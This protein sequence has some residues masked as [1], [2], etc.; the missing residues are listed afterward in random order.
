M[1]IKVI[2]LAVALFFSVSQIFGQDDEI[3]KE[4]LKHESEARKFAAKDSAK[5]WTIGGVGSLTFSQVALSNWQ[6]G[7]QNSMAVGSLFNV[8]ANY[9]K[10]NSTWDNKLEIAYGQIR[11]GDLGMRKSDDRVV[12]DSKFGYKATNSLFYSAM[13]NF[14]SQMTDGFN[15]DPTANKLISAL[16]APAYLVFSAGIDY[17]YK[18]L[19]SVFASPVTSKTTIVAN[20]E[21]SNQGLY[22]VTVGE[23]VRSEF[24]GFVK[25]WFKKDLFQ[26]VSL[27][28]KADF[29]SNYM[30]NAKYVDVNWETLIALKVNKYL[31]ANIHTHLIYDHDII[32]KEINKPG[33]Q[34]K[35]VFGLGISYK[36]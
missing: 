12:L 22:G 27:E 33:I 21:L 14:K 18:K 17:K 24:G 15:Y 20:E 23:K 28:T 35:E 26:N 11:Q 34:F 5:L 4:A 16:F 25:I 30:H 3:K 7:G 36:F 6:G 9:E 10:G 32:I 8:F 31:S 1:K 2:L 19:F 29:F 13:F